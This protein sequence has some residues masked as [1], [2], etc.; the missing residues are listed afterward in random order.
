MTE[1]NGS[2]KSS[3]RSMA[4]GVAELG[5]DA[6]AL[7]ELQMQLVQ[8]EF[9]LWLKA[10]TTPAVLLAVAV[11]VALGSVPVLLLALAYLLVEFAGLTRTLAFSIATVLGLSF[12]GIAAAVGIRQLR[13]NL[14]RFERS[15]EEFQRNIR[16]VKQVLKHKANPTN[17]ES[18]PGPR[19][20]QN[21]PASHT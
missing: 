8:S 12:A 13:N 20:H 14:L 9:K 7:F 2:L 17:G 21:E 4:R 6:V 10:F 11:C 15:R 3:A 19:F 5:H 16:W 18:G 1:Q